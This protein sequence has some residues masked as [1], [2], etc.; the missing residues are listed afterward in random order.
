MGRSLWA[1][2]FP[3]S[4]LRGSQVDYVAAVEDAD[5]CGRR[6]RRREGD[7]AH[8]W[9]HGIAREPA[10]REPW[11][12]GYAMHHT[13]SADVA[14]LISLGRGDSADHLPFPSDIRE[15]HFFCVCSLLNKPDGTGERHTPHGG[16]GKKNSSEKDPSPPPPPDRDRYR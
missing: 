16:S 14:D 10:A 9:A 2:A 3:H 8:V 1:A 7:E 15:A 6:R 11:D 5:A 13:E 4:C 12:L